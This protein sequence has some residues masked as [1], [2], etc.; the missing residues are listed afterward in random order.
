MTSAT[1]CSPSSAAAGCTRCTAATRSP[2]AATIGATVR[3]NTV[4]VVG[5]VHRTYVNGSLKHTVSGESGSF[6]DKFGA[7]RTAGG[8][9]PASVEWS[10]IR[11]WRKQ[12]AA[13]PPGQSSYTH[14]DPMPRTTFSYRLRPVG[15]EGAAPTGLKATVTQADGVQRTTGDDPPSPTT[16]ESSP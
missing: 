16:E 12:G 10:G 6:Y 15:S 14:P 1:S 13:V 9:G 4:H 5:G 2:R 11:F 7:H 8:Q 3:V